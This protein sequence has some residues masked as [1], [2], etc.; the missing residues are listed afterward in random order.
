MEWKDSSTGLVDQNTPEKLCTTAREIENFLISPLN[1]IHRGQEF[2][3]KWET[4]GSW[5]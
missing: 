4:S 1:T 3:R 2:N 5:R